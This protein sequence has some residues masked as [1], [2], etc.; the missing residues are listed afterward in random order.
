MD[1]Y[2]CEH[3][4]SPST[5]T[6]SFKIYTKLGK[7]FGLH[8]SSLRRFAAGDTNLEDWSY[9][10]SVSVSGNSGNRT[11]TGGPDDWCSIDESS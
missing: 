5:W 7:L 10:D 9:D 11:G 8:R 4:G 6:K 2:V 3:G 1:A